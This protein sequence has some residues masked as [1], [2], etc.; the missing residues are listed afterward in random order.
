MT[1][2][3]FIDT[4]RTIEG[5]QLYAPTCNEHR[6]QWFGPATY[7]RDAAQDNGTV[8]NTDAHRASDNQLDL[9]SHNSGTP[10]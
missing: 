9:E 3:A 10:S 5:K 4:L 2:P 7:M 1:G 6:A 8:H